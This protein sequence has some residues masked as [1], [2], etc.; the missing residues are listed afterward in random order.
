MNLTDIAMIKGSYI[1]NTS[2]WMIAFS[3]VRSQNNVFLYSVEY[4]LGKNVRELSGCWECSNSFIWVVHLL[5]V[6]YSVYYTW[7][8]EKGKKTVFKPQN[9]KTDNKTKPKNKQK[10]T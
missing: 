3:H 6:N 7:L 4:S 5:C 9:T 2:F 8:I 1:Q 10:N